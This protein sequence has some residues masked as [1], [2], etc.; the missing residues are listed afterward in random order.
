[1]PADSQSRQALFPY[2]T[3]GEDQIIGHTNQATDPSEIWVK[4][5]VW[6]RPQPRNWGECKLIAGAVRAALDAPIA[7]SGHAV[8]AH[9]F[10]NVLFRKEPD[11]LTRRAIVTQRYLTGP[12]VSLIY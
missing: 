7:M 8:I 1:M 4:V 10:H 3:I 2:V 9:T 5:E 11:G 6:S 12:A